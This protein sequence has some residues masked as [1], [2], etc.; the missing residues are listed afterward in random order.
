ML[1]SVFSL[2]SYRRWKSIRVATNVRETFFGAFLR[3]RTFCFW[4]LWV[5]IYRVAFIGHREIRDIIY[6]ENKIEE[7]VLDLL[8]RYEFVEFNLGRNGDF[9]ISAASAIKRAQ[10]KYGTQNSSLNLILPYKSKDEC[11]FEKYYDEIIY[12]WDNY[13]HFKSAIKKRNEW[14]IDN[15]DLLICYVEENRQG[16]AMTAL[17]Y[18]QTKRIKIVNLAIK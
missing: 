9:D 14:M 6:V 3:G 16:G 4:V 15:S 1:K 8:H 11:C 2:Y 17:K 5:D 10:K 12:P 18:A 7:L 13:T